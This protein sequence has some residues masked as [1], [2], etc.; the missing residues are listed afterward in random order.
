[1]IKDTIITC[2][3]DTI[4]HKGQILLKEGKYSQA[5]NIL[6]PYK[7]INTSIAYL[8]LDLN[9]AAEQVL[10]KIKHS[11]KRDYLLAI[12]ERRLGNSKRAAQYLI[13]S[14]KEDPS[15]RFRSHLDPEISSLITDYNINI[16]E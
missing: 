15:M 11:A 12:T 4:Y 6:R 2:I 8:S 7:D 1:M 13:N 9:I 16:F 10:L 14:I 5:L 3:P